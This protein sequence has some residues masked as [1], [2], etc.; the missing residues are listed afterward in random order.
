MGII[1]DFM[2][3]YF[4]ADKAMDNAVTVQCGKN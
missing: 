4:Y 3:F 2:H 1:D